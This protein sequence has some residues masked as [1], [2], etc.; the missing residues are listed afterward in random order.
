MN[1]PTRST[2]AGIAKR[3]QCLGVVI[4]L[5]GCAP[6]VGYSHLSDPRI[7]DDGYDLV[8]GGAKITNALNLSFG[9]CRNLAN[10]E[11]TLIKI[12]IEYVLGPEAR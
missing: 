5:V 6:F 1:W 10:S 12:D 8:C 2:L 4:C 3:A 9:V 11:G 7:N